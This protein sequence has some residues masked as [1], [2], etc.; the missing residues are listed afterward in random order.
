MSRKQVRP[1][2]GDD[3]DEPVVQQE[4]RAAAKKTRDDDLDRLIDEMDELLPLT[5][6]EADVIVR[7]YVQ[8]G[9]Q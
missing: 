9:G 4:E 8:K 5:E 3:D 6:E 2:G 7:E 1:N